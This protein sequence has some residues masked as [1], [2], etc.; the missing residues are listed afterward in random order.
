METKDNLGWLTCFQGSEDE[1]LRANAIADQPVSN[2]VL[3]MLTEHPAV[4]GLP[5]Y[6]GFMGFLPAR[7]LQIGDRIEPFATTGMRL[8]TPC[9]EIPE[10]A[11]L[12]PLLARQDPGTHYSEKEIAHAQGALHKLLEE[13]GW[14]IRTGY[15]GFHERNNGHHPQQAT[16]LLVRDTEGQL[17]ELPPRAD[18]TYPLDFAK[19][20]SIKDVIPAAAI[21]FDETQ[22]LVRAQIERM[23]Y[24]ETDISGVRIVDGNEYEADHATYAGFLPTVRGAD[25]TIE[26]SLHSNIDVKGPSIG[27]YILLPNTEAITKALVTLRSFK[28]EDHSRWAEDSRQKADRVFEQVLSDA[29]VVKIEGFSGAYVQYGALD[30]IHNKPCNFYGNI[31]AIH[32]GNDAAL[33][34]LPPGIYTLEQ[35]KAMH[36]GKLSLPE[37][38]QS[39]AETQRQYEALFFPEKKAEEHLGK[40][41]IELYANPEYYITVTATNPEGVNGEYVVCTRTL[42][43]EDG[44]A[45]IAQYLKK[46]FDA[47]IDYEKKTILYKGTDT[48]VPGMIIGDKGWHIQ[49]LSRS[50]GLGRYGFQLEAP[51]VEQ[52]SNVHKRKT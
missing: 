39:I 12:L 15:T 41:W 47:V 16:L 23:R 17:Y 46:R 49:F 34:E 24:Q 50:C 20:A 42:P 6:P 36:E 30:G 27:A 26:G 45:G 18:A 32:V 44:P 40:Q 7:A 13:N 38:T 1:V 10:N 43:G 37:N 22:R 2:D 11:E 19:R 48:G 52:L 4:R 3:A 31:F 28:P 5:P 21:P 51:N 29:G 33:Y 35:L 14:I 8:N 9:I 25:S